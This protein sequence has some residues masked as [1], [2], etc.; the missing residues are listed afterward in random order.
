MKYLLIILLTALFISCEDESYS[1]VPDITVDE[2]FYLDDPEFQT[3]SVSVGESIALDVSRGGYAGI[4]L[5]HAPGIIHAFDLCCPKHVVA[6]E[7]LWIDGVAGPELL[8][9]DGAIAT[10]PTD[11]A[12]F[13]M[14]E[15]DPVE[16]NSKE[17]AIMKSYRTSQNGNVLRVYN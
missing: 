16:I 3:F 4:I 5:F 12:T 14:L 10:C 9:I 11:S 17:P 7:S 1:N 2:I 8:M 13:N 15:N 6:P